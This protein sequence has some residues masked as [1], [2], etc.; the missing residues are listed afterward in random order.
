MSQAAVIEDLEDLLRSTASGDEA[1]FEALYRAAAPRLLGL[2]VRKIGTRDAAEDILQETFVQIWRNAARFDP[3]L[4]AAMAWMATIARN[5]AVD[6][7]RRLR[8]DLPMVSLPDMAA[9]DALATAPAADALSGSESSS[10]LKC[11]KAL[12]A[13][14]RRAIVLSYCYGYTHDELA[15]ALRL[16]LGTVKGAIRRSLPLLKACLES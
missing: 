6:R 7:L 5:A 10:I 9:I 13:T 12:E 4:G 15:K 11:L 3:A 14:T 16:P 1:A 8:R 2:L